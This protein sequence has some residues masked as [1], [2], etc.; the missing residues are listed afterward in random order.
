[1]WLLDHNLPRQVYDVLKSLS[2]TCETTDNRGWDSLEN[3]DLV[4]VASDAGFVCILTRDVLFSLSAA[5]A[6]KKYPNFAV[7][8]IRLPQAKGSVYAAS[9]RECWNRQK[10]EPVGGARIEWPSSF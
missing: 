6:L 5:K 7:V 1:M 3:G 8:L 10:I 2:V 4:S 9:F